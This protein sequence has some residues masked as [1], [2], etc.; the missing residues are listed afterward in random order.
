MGIFWPGF[1]SIGHVMLGVSGPGHAPQ[2]FFL[3]FRPSEITSGGFSV[4][5]EWG[6]RREWEIPSVRCQEC[7]HE[8]ERKCEC[9]NSLICIV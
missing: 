8:K 1:I 5:S 3:K 6:K 2:E 7:E 4:G 9:G